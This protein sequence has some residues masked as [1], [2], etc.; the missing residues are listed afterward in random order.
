M[1]RRTLKLLAA[2]VAALAIIAPGPL[3]AEARTAP[4]GYGC[5]ATHL[6]RRGD[7]LGRLAVRYRTTVALIRAANGLPGTRIYIGQRL[8]IPGGTGLFPVQPTSVRYIQAQA[9]VNIRSG[10]GTSF[11][12]IGFLA[13]GQMA[14]VTG[15]SQHG[16][17]W[18]VYC[19]AGDL[20]GNCFVSSDPELTVPTGTP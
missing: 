15:L 3:P 5:Q 18:R 17:W 12:R 10:P 20:I 2:A 6:V 4:E 13:E 8:C 9:N 1:F 11:Q 19:P 7:T 16:S 14:G